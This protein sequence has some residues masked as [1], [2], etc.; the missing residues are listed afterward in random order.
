M[1]DDTRLNGDPLDYR[2]RYADALIASIREEQQDYVPL[3]T[4]QD[5]ILTTPTTGCRRWGHHRNPNHGHCNRCG[6]EV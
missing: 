2:N 3:T 6:Q 4:F 5:K 1:S